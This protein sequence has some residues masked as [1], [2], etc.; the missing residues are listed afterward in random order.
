MMDTLSIFT[1]IINFVALSVS[2][3]L[4][5]YI[6]TRSPR[7]LVSWLTSFTLWSM[8]GIFF[9]MLLALNPPPISTQAPQW[10]QALFPF[11]T[12]EVVFGEG[13]GWLTGW[14]ATPAIAFWH[15]ATVE[16]RPG[17]KSVWQKIRVWLVYVTALIAIIIQILNPYIIIDETSGPVYSNTLSPDLIYTTFMSLLFLFACLSFLN[18][19]QSAR[20]APSR[21]A[22]RQFLALS[23]ATIIAG[24]TGPVSLI[25]TEVVL[26]PRAINTVLLIIPVALIGFSVAR[27]SALIDGRTI[28]R[29]FVYNGTAIGVITL[30]Y[31]A[32]TWISVQLFNVP[33]AAF[34]FVILL[35]ITSHS[36]IDVTRRNLDFIFY[37][38]EDRDLRRNL[39]G[40][41]SRMGEQDPEETLE[42]I[43]DST[44]ESVRATYG[45]VLLFE[46]QSHRLAASC[47]WQ[48]DLSQLPVSTFSADDLMHLEP[49]QFP[50]PLNEAALLI[51]L[52]AETNQV[53]VMF[54]GPPINSAIR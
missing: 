15:H 28:R 23:I 31:S 9:N 5:W 18:L 45:F 17:R 40:L 14:Q 39:R 7:R 33:P 4:G 25:T 52:Y 1:S 34:V 21:I 2:V 12:S 27:Y 3:W 26:L 44:C 29:D 51:P 8:S 43:L 20:T 24:L 38:K 47:N 36:L 48:D 54:F 49:G 30:I 22:R 42:L 16:L 10:V 46:N 13:G 6:L 50:S 41:A 53:G 11:W 32:I 35:A 19:I 37:R